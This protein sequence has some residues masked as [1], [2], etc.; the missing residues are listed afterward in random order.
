[1]NGA[2]RDALLVHC[3]RSF[4]NGGYVS[5]FLL[6]STLSAACV[7]ALTASAALGQS[8][9]TA[10]A[11]TIAERSM[12]TMMTAVT[13]SPE[14]TTQVV[15]AAE[16]ETQFSIRPVNADVA[17]VVRRRESF[18]RPAVLMI[19]GAA[20]LVTGLIVDGDASSILIISGAGIGAYGLYLHLQTPNA[21]FTR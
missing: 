3:Q 5:R 13:M 11:V 12:P 18:G 16:I 9:S 1:L 4:T 10:S 20:L 17:S 2:R 21:R 8:D 14:M 15:P 7:V 19:T 6:R